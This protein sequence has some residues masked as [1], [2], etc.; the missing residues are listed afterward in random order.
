M[1]ERPSKPS[2]PRD[3]VML[4]RA[5]NTF[6]KRRPIDR[7]TLALVDRALAKLREPNRLSPSESERLRRSKRVM[8]ARLV[9][10]LKLRRRPAAND[11]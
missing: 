6:L 2:I 3:L 1:T 4:A 8:A 5:R 11:E 9:G 7:K 10:L